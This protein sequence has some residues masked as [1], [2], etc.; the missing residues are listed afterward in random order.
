MKDNNTNIFA[1]YNAQCIKTNLSVDKCKEC[2]DL[3]FTEAG[4]ICAKANPTTD[5]CNVLRDDFNT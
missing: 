1:E 3:V 2:P 5:T 4:L